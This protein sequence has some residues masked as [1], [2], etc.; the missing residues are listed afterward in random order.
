[1]V[2]DASRPLRPGSMSPS[3]HRSQ[4]P[5]G[6]HTQAQ[7]GAVVTQSN[8]G[9]HKRPGSPHPSRPPTPNRHSNTTQS[10]RRR[11]IADSH[12]KVQATYA[13]ASQDGTGTARVSVISVNY[14]PEPDRSVESSDAATKIAK[15]SVGD[16]VIRHNEL[17]IVVGIDNSL[18]PPSYTLRTR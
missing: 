5:G 15:L 12:A 16:H 18:D 9:A 17:Y 14:N 2:T 10:E 6:S 8:T 3:R 13:E 11:A 7:V 4:S 1:M